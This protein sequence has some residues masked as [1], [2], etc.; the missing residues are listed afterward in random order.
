MVVF[1]RVPQAPRSLF[2]L[3][4]MGYALHLNLGCDASAIIHPLIYDY[5]TGL[6]RVNG[7][8][9]RNKQEYIEW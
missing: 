7:V 4:Q 9:H 1:G 8:D 6:E 5:S 3:M 2:I